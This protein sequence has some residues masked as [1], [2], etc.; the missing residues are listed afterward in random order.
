MNT[1]PRKFAEVNANHRGSKFAEIKEDKYLSVAPKIGCTYLCTGNH[2]LSELHK[3]QI[4]KHCDPNLFDELQEFIA[5]FRN[6][7]NIS[8]AIKKYIS[9]NVGKNKDQKSLL[10][11]RQLNT[12]F[13]LQI[14]SIFHL[15]TGSGGKEEFTIHGFQ[16]N[17]TFE[18]VWLD[19]FHEI[20]K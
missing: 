6:E 4:K 3:K 16:D 17:N 5:R 14:D 19:P 8:D 18:I 12:K 15:H 9:H 13:N 11:I 1:E 2:C 7:N 10:K 20:Y